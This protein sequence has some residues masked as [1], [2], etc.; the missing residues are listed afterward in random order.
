MSNKPRSKLV[1]E[2]VLCK[3]EQGCFPIIYLSDK[4]SLNLPT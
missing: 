3:N 2:K 4:S 1:A